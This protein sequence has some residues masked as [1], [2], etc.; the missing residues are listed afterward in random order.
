M[1]LK[2]YFDRELNLTS[3][4]GG[5]G[6]PADAIREF[7]NPSKMSVFVGVAGGAKFA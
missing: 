7:P 4:G 6:E 3:G 5:F 1:F 2:N